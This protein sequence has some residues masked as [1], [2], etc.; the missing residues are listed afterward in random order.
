MNL[1]PS[2]NTH[3][4][5]QPPKISL[6]TNSAILN[7]AIYSHIILEDKSLHDMSMSSVLKSILLTEDVPEQNVLDS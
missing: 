7:F 6:K 1:C 5:N 4:Q 2:S 3:K